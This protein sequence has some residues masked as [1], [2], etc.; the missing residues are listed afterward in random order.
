MRFLF[1]FLILIVFSSCEAPREKALKRIQLEEAGLNKEKSPRL[2]KFQVEKLINSYETFSNDFPEDSLAPVY[3]F[4]AGEYSRSL[5]KGK[6]AI[7]Y[8]ERTLKKYPNIKDAPY[9]FFLEGYVYENLIRDTSNARKKYEEFLR[10]YPTHELV[11]SVKF[12]LDNLGKSEEE[13]IKGFEKSN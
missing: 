2:N 9:C 10:K 6:E 7:A 13:I 3:L 11:Q 12:S 4:K 1:L 8:Y 5:G